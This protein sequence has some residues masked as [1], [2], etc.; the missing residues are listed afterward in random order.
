[1]INKNGFTL[2]EL[3]VVVATAGILAAIAVA[4]FA[5]YRSRAYDT[6]ALADLKNLLSAQEAYFVDNNNYA[7][8]KASIPP[9]GGFGCIGPGGDLCS[10]VLPGFTAASPGVILQTDVG[11]MMIGDPYFVAYSCHSQ[12]KNQFDY[13]SFN[14]VIN[15]NA[16][17]DPSSDC[18]YASIAF[19]GGGGGGSVEVG[20]GGDVM[21]PP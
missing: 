14:R 3:L 20:G 16:L 12:G 21:T 11:G 10:E 1:M 19:N 18:A 9:C 5:E 7:T 8:C 6:A 15:K 2:V 17:P 4:Q 13:D